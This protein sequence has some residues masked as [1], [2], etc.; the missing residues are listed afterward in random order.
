MGRSTT[1]SPEKPEATIS[2][3]GLLLITLL[4]ALIAKASESVTVSCDSKGI[5]NLASEDMGPTDAKQLDTIKIEYP[6]TGPNSVLSSSQ[7]SRAEITRLVKL[8]VQNDVDPYLALSVLLLENPPIQNK[9]NSDYAERYGILPVDEIALYSELGCFVPLDKINQEFSAPEDLSQVDACKRASDYCGGMIKRTGITPKYLQTSLKKVKQ[10]CTEFG[11]IGNEGGASGFYDITDQD[12]SN[13]DRWTDDDYL[14]PKEKGCCINTGYS[15]KE[16][17]D[18]IAINYL[19][20]AIQDRVAHDKSIPLSIQRYNGL[21]YFGQTEKMPNACYQGLHMVDR[22]IYGARAAD[23]MV[24]TLL[25]NAEI[26]QIVKDAAKSKKVTSI[27][28]LADGAGQHLIQTDK[29]FVDQQN[30]LLKGASGK[31]SAR[32]PNGHFVGGGTEDKNYLE[33]ENERQKACAKYF[34]ISPS[35]GLTP[36]I[37]VK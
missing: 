17:R 5:L 4:L 22:P 7:Y 34:G 10:W 21:G 37:N 12:N 24:S 6:F 29:F 32:L 27:F 28:C 19:K 9:K 33:L 16:F 20:N 11:S 26:A 23:F 18:I 1:L 15:F 8:A 25:E 30:Y 35:S 2:K 13:P 3:C 36:L 14:N 31:Y